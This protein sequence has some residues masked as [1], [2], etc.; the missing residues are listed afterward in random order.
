MK[1]AVVISPAFPASRVVLGA[2]NR[3]PIHATVMIADSGKASALA[4]QRARKRALCTSAHS[5][6]WSTRKAAEVYNTYIAAVADEVVVLWD[7]KDANT[8]NAIQA[9]WATG[10][11]R[12]V[13]YANGRV[14]D[15]RE[16]IERLSIGQAVEGKGE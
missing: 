9:A 8:A 12:G 7:G 2:I 11:L 4:I 14:T 3:I 1:V 16:V 10:R 6:S 13:C 5:A 15:G